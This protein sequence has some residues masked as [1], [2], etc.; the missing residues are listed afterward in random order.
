MRL[1]NSE[2]CIVAGI[3]FQ[4]KLVGMLNDKTCADKMAK[5]VSAAKIMNIPVILTEQYPKGLGS[6]IPEISQFGFETIEKTS[7]SAFQQEEFKKVIL[8]CGK[9]QV[10]IG[11][12]ETHICVH[13]TVAE[14]LDAGFEVFVVKDACGSR[15]KE[16]F[17]C[18]IG[19]MKDNGAKIT[20]LEVV[21][22]E[23]LR[24]SR[25]PNFKE[26]QALIK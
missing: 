16:E 20:C 10:I 13:Q 23:L 26:V 11:G 17:E 4:E 22:F 14:L 9:K 6:T 24:S 3:D 7:F 12:I 25:H 15:H 18:G 8:S 1:I 5:L 21:L 2:N 19:R